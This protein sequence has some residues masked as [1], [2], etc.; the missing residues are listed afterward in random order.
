[1]SWRRAAIAPLLTLLAPIAVGCGGGGSGDACVDVDLT[2]Q[3]LYEPTFDNIH[4]RT[5]AA[6][7]AVS[8][9]ACHSRAGAQNGLVMEDADTAYDDLLRSRVTPGDPS[10]SLMIRRIQS[11]DPDFQ[12]P[13][14][15]PLS[16]AERCVLI[17]WVEAGAER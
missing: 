14:G 8:G 4:Q 10:C 13:P 6:K 5:L 12:M 7:C 17:Q 16:A 9:S 1:V 11:G 15:A 3:P 2:C